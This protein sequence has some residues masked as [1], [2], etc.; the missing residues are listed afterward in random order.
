MIDLLVF[1]A[2]YCQPCKQ[3]E[4]AGVYA[5]VK[6]AGFEV[7]KIDTQA[8]PTFAAQNHVSAIPTLIIRKDKVPVAR[9]VGARDAK[10]LIAEMQKFV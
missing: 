9:I 8:N 1:S 5:A 2:D 3:M 10:T 6:N 4:S 7:E